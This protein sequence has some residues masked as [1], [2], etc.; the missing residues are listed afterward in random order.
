MSLLI[1]DPI[2]LDIYGHGRN[3]RKSQGYGPI[4]IYPGA[5]NTHTAIDKTIHGRKRR[6][7]SQ[8]F[9]DAALRAS[10][11]FII[12]KVQKLCDALFPPSSSSTETDIGGWT[13]PR[14]MAKWS[15][16]FT[17]PSPSG[18]KVPVAARFRD[19]GLYQFFLVQMMPP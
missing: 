2:D 14:N 12:D 10:E 11:P 6:I 7:V 8:G 16:L 3:I 13:E 19:P 17:A 4:P 18:H 15:M 9:S 5:Y 1:A